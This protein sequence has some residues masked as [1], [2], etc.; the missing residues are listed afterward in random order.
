MSHIT[1]KVW[2]SILNIGE[3]RSELSAVAARMLLDGRYILNITYPNARPEEV[4]R[5]EIIKEFKKSGYDFLLMIDADVIP[6][7]NP[8]DLVQLD[9]D[10]VNF[11][12]PQWREGD[13]YW[14]ALDKVEGGWKPLPVERRCGLQEVDATGNACMLIKRKVFDV[15]P[16]PYFEHKFDEEGIHK[17]GM[18]YRFCQKAKENGFKVFVHFDFMADHIK[19]ISLVEVLNLLG[20]K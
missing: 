18:E 1:K 16:T 20:G 14:V 19:E 11:A 8:L 6:L 5:N 17:E 13:I 4:N 7:R 10:I 9:L 3:I 2:V 12:C 15:V